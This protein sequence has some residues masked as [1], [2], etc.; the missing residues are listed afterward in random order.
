MVD[1]NHREHLVADI[2]TGM[3]EDGKPEI[4]QVCGQ[5]GNNS[6]CVSLEAEKRCKRL[7]P[8]LPRVT[9]TGCS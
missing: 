8:S 9:Q 4:H 7:I 2:N 1:V 5:L 6:F 3:G